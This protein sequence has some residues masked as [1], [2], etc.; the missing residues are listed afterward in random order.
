MMQKLNFLCPNG[1]FNF[2][3]YDT[4]S[5][6]D[7]FIKSFLLI[8]SYFI[9]AIIN[10]FIYSYAEDLSRHV[11]C[12]V[13][14]SLRLIIFMLL[15]LTLASLFVKY[16]LNIDGNNSDDINGITITLITDLYLLCALTLH[17]AVLFNKSI[18]SFFPICLIISFVILTLTNYVNFINYLYLNMEKILKNNLNSFEI[19]NLVS[20]VFFNTFLFAYNS[21]IIYFIQ[22]KKL[23]T[24]FKTNKYDNLNNEDDEQ[25]CDKNEY[26]S[27]EDKANYYSYLT[28]AWLKPLM[29]KGYKCK[30]EHVEDLS[31]LPV[32]LNI[33]KICERFLTNYWPKNLNKNALNEYQNN[34]IVKPDLLL[35]AEFIENITNESKDDLNVTQAHLLS[36]L[37]RCFGK[38][39]L[40]LGV[41]KLLN[42]CVNFSG[43]LLLDQLVQFVEDQDS[44]LKDG[45][46]YAT[47]LF[48][49][50][51]IGSF[52]NI[53]FT[54]A[55]NKLCLK[56]KIALIIKIYRK[57]ILV[58]LDEMNKLSTGQ[59]VNHMSIDTDSIVNCVPNI[60][61]LWSMPFQLIVTFY[62]LYY[63]IGISFVSLF[64]FLTSLII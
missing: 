9:F 13:I 46:M 16:F 34:P 51:L 36:A 40:I 1:T 43:P 33:V 23:R 64:L 53:H 28:F 47:A 62:L 21:V 18:F 37:F 48:I 3:D 54:N 61:S 30:I 50:A 32:E 5:L 26:K 41:F 58:R 12:C 55:M 60:H 8:P 25:Q 20:M 11:K 2:I 63:Q 29:D 17:T 57:A 22:N 24:S 52:I 15:L 59:I 35:N 42:D 4:N 39:F 49:T 38:E 31:Q 45:C 56:I 27:D 6:G 14:N 44:K 19:L 7:C 10:G